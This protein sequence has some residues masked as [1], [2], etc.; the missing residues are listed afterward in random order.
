[1]IT[2]DLSKHAMAKDKQNHIQ[3]NSIENLHSIPTY[4]CCQKSFL[5]YAMVLKPSRHWWAET[6]IWFGRQFVHQNVSRSI[7]SCLESKGNI[8]KLAGLPGHSDRWA[9]YEPGVGEAIL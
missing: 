7:W 8:S 6:G 2:V 5:L 9:E 4:T 3:V 1:M